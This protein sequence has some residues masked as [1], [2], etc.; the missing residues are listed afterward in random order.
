MLSLLAPA[1]IN[2]FLHILGRRPDGYHDLQ[3]VFQ[4]LDYGDQLSFNLRKDQKILLRPILEGVPPEENLIFKAAVKLQNASGCAKG[5]DITL[6]K[7]LPM[8]G[9][10]GGGSSNAATTLLG[11]NHIWN[12]GLTTDELAEL[13]QELGADVPVF[14]RGFTAWAEGIG[15]QLQAVDLPAL[16]YLVLTPNCQVSTAEI[17]SHRELTRDSAAITV[18]A[19][20]KQGGHNDCQPLVEKLYPD[21]KNVVTWLKQ[22]SPAT[23]STL[24]TGTGASVFTSFETESAAKALL[25]KSPWQGFVA[26]GIQQSPVHQRISEQ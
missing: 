8:G 24:M 13:G 7:R 23:S 2:L 25:A 1:K 3:T 18:A 9:G 10:L 15:E 16:F 21:V 26:K 17:F 14:I 12:C 4:L 20:L 22:H 19:F 11:L 6:S 5:A